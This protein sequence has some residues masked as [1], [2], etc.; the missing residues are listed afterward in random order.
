MPQ[1]TPILM[2]PP[3]A[4]GVFVGHEVSHPGIS[5]KPVPGEPLKNPFADPTDP[6]TGE[7]ISIDNNPPNAAA[8]SQNAG[9]SYYHPGPQ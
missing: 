8:Y 5:R 4:A 1:S 2:T 3:T 6:N 9:F 7:S